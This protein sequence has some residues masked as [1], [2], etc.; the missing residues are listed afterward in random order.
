MPKINVITAIRDALD[1]E[2]AA[3]ERVIVMGEDVGKIGGVFRAT[4]GLWQKYGGKRVIDM[5][6][7][8]G[9]IVGAAIG[10]ALNGMRPV[11]E[12]QFVDYMHPAF[13]QIVNEA[14]K[15]RYRSAGGFHCPIVVRAP[16]GG[17]I[18]GALYHSQSLEAFFCHSPGLKVVAPAT[19]YDAKGLLKAA[20]RD[21]DPVVYLESKATYRTVTGEVPVEDY[22]V[23]I[24]VA[25]V[26]R[27]GE[28]L[29]FLT[30]GAMVHEALKAADRLAGEDIDVEVVDLRTL[31]P[32]DCEAILASVRRTGKVLIIHEANKTCGLGAEL[33]ALINEE[34]FE[35]LDAPIRRLTGPDVPAIPFASSLEAAFM[36]S[37]EKIVQVAR[38]LAAY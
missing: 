15:I 23:P 18:H 7:A 6:I 1:E 12:I 36:P 31:A 38:R 30:Y 9:A 17:G 37:A 32:L 8:E 2:M 24:G 20:I 21:P 16:S 35:Y 29:T 3:D 5:P 13:D 11:A 28:H 33:A 26:K 27:R 25:D 34:A 4:E 14:A 22:I 10:A 19:P